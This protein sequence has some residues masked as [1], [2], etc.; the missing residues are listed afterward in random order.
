MVLVLESYAGYYSARN[1]HAKS[2]SYY[3]EAI[4]LAKK[5]NFKR[6]LAYLLNNL[7][8]TVRVTGNSE[9]AIPIYLESAHAY[10]EL[11]DDR[12]V[13]GAYL[14]VCISFIAIED[15]KSAKDVLYKSLEH[16]KTQADSIRYYGTIHERLAMTFE[17]EGDLEKVVEHAQIALS[18]FEQYP[19]AKEE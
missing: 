10:E 4:D 18:F 16:V 6:K 13:L 14:S 3:S 12:G 11:G 5:L 15:Y 19:N 8:W 2:Y 17:R 7:A 1:D 9:R